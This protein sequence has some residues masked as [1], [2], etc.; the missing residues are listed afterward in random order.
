[1]HEVVNVFEGD[2][3]NN[4]YLDFLAIEKP[5]IVTKSAIDVSPDGATLRLEVLSIGG[6]IEEQ[7]LSNSFSFEL[8][9]FETLQAWYSTIDLAQNY[10]NGEKINDWLDLSGSNKHFDN[11]SGD[12][13][14]LLSGLKG[15]PVINFDGNDLLWTTHDFDHLTNNR[16]TIQL[17]R[18]TLARKIIGNLCNRN[19]FGFHGSPRVDGTGRV[20]IN[21]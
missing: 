16:Y 2:F 10:N 3:T 8:N 14:V 4:G 11:V 13:T 15:K 21:M 12:P 18:D 7:S 5:E 1:M 6:E 20:D 19:L 9:T 17:W